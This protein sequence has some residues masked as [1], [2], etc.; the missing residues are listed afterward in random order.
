V[1]KALRHPDGADA[2]GYRCAGAYFLEVP[3]V[4]VPS[5]GSLGKGASPRGGT[6]AQ[7]ENATYRE[8]GHALVAKYTAAYPAS[9]RPKRVFS[10]VGQGDPVLLGFLAT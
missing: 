7:R 3:S 10:S 9:P 6:G 5:A 4:R 2:G 1:G 8:E